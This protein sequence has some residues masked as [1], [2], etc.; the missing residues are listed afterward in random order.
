METDPKDLRGQRSD[1]VMFDDAIVPPKAPDC[2]VPPADLEPVDKRTILEAGE[3]PV[4]NHVCGAGCHHEKKPKKK[5]MVPRQID[6][7]DVRRLLANN[8][9]ALSKKFNTAFV[10][11]D[12]RS[13]KIAELWAA[14]DMH[15]CNLLGWKYKHVRV[16]RTR[17]REE[18]KP[19]QPEAKPALESKVEEGKPASQ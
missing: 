5:T 15:A 2:V 4:E 11:L 8:Y 6:D 7:R 16:L 19:A 12:E 1:A 17:K 3:K 10:L 13:G 14:S 18:P 9:E